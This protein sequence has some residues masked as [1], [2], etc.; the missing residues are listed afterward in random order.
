MSDFILGLAL[1]AA[2][3]AV[4]VSRELKREGRR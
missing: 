2:L 4:C 1:G 3:V